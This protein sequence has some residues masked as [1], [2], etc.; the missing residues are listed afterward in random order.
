MCR[1]V[2]CALALALGDADV[3]QAFSQLAHLL[4]TPPLLHIT[5][6]LM[7]HG[8]LGAIAPRVALPLQP[9]PHHP[10]LFHCSPMIPSF[11]LSQC[12]PS[13]SHLTRWPACQSHR[14]SWITRLRVPGM[15]LLF[16]AVHV[17]QVHASQSQQ[18][19]CDAPRCSGPQAHY[20]GPVN[21]PWCPFHG[22]VLPRSGRA[23]CAA[24]NACLGLML[25]TIC[26]EQGM[27]GMC[28]SSACIDYVPA[29]YTHRPSLLLMAE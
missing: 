13:Y 3:E 5:T 24:V 16:G 6:K 21:K 25:A 29:I 17:H 18:Q 14:G 9:L 7:C 27:H 10:L 19:V 12:L 11:K 23:T 2:G 8:H 4:A 28:T 22:T 20:T 15:L 26:H 1:L